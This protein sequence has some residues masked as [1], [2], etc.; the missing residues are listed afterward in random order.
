ME[1]IGFKSHQGCGFGICRREGD[2]EASDERFV[3]PRVAH[4]EH[5]GPESG[6]G[7]GEGEVDAFGE[8][9]KD[10]CTGGSD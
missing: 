2:D 1:D 5:A 7:G 4:E 3:W 9:R 8:V 6:V 10:R